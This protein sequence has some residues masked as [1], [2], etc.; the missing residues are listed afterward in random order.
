MSQPHPVHAQVLSPSQETSDLVVYLGVM[1]AQLIR[2]H[3]P[4]HAE[5]SM[6][7]GAP[8]AGDQHIVVAVFDKASGARIENADVTAVVSGLGHVGTTRVRLDPMQIAGTVTYGG[9]V[10]MSGNDRY[11]IAVEI[12]RPG[13]GSPEAAQFTYVSQAP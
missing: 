2:G 10:P 11:T 3:P 4:S 6:H 8:S 9:F 5:A 7:G 13:A 1:P 12:R